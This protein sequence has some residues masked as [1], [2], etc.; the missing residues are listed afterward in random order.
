MCTTVMKY[1]IALQ[2]S[3]GRKKKKAGIARGQNSYLDVIVF[4]L[5]AVS[6]DWFIFGAWL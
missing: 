1:N 3:V 2:Q 4:V 6:A 5:V